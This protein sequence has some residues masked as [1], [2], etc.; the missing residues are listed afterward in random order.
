[1][2]TKISSSR[3]ERVFLYFIYIALFASGKV[4]LRVLFQCSARRRKGRRDKR[5]EIR[6]RGGE[7]EIRGER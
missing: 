7:G 5:R 1:M 6:G 2:G 3:R 4:A